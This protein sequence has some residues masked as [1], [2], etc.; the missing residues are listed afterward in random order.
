M[1]E[2]IEKILELVK[3]PAAQLSAEPTIP[4]DFES[5]EPVCGI[6]SLAAP[7]VGFVVF[8]VRVGSIRGDPGFG[9][10]IC[11]LIIMAIAFLVGTILAIWAL[12]RGERYRAL[13]VVGLVLNLLPILVFLIG[14]V[15]T[16]IGK[17]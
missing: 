8:M 11:L 9:V 17:L 2:E 3:P 12:R 15:S 4:D 5:E 1:A 16:V 14:A 10:I 6:L 7:F 13:P